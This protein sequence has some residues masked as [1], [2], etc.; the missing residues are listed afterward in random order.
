MCTLFKGV[1]YGLAVI[2][3][4]HPNDQWNSFEGLGIFNEGKL[5]CG[6]LLCIN[7]LGYVKSHSLMKNGRPAEGHYGTWFN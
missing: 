6:P 3:L 4:K 7:N 5:D 1:P 2:S